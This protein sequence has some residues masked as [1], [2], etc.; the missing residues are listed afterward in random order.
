MSQAC[1]LAWSCFKCLSCYCIC[2][3]TILMFRV[4][5]SQPKR[6]AL[7]EMWY[8][9]KGKTLIQI[10][11]KIIFS[12]PERWDWSYLN[13]IQILLSGSTLFN[14]KEHKTTYDCRMWIISFQAS[15][16]CRE[17]RN[18]L[19]HLLYTQGLS[20]WTRWPA[21]GMPWNVVFSPSCL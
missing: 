9:I 20:K 21:F 2:Y 7:Y 16:A 12:P 10:L 5:I 6:F 1:I 11:I 15:F 13:S 14:A 8:G 17:A 19:R 4:K 3:C 18:C